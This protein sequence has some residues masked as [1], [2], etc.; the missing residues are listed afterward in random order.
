ML[1]RL[2]ELQLEYIQQRP[3]FRKN[4][5]FRICTQIVSAIYFGNFYI[6]LCFRKVHY[7]NE[8]IWETG[9]YISNETQNKNSD[10]LTGC[11]F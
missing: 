9:L 7:I 10:N 8:Y 5:F 4:I 1:Y 11:D 6:W 2:D 3:T